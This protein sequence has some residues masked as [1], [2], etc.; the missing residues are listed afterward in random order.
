MK[1][2]QVLLVVGLLITVSGCS[3]FKKSTDPQT[4]IQNMLSKTIELNS[5]AFNATGKI[6]SKNAV[7]ATT[8]D[9]DLTLQGG[10]FLTETQLPDLDLSMG[11]KVKTT[12]PVDGEI[13]GSLDLALKVV[14]STIYL[15]LVDVMLPLDI[16][17]KI[18]S[19]IDLY[20]GKW[21][22]IPNTLLPDGI[23]NQ[24]E[25]TAESNAKKVKIKELVKKTQFFE[26]IESNEEGDNYVYK[27]KFNTDN[28]KVF[29]QEVGKINNQEVSAEELA[30]LQDLN[31]I[32][33]YSFTLYI[34]QKTHYLDKMILSL[35][36]KEEGNN[37]EI[38]FSSK[39]N[40]FN[41]LAK[42]TAPDGAEEFNPMSLMGLGMMMESS[43]GESL[44]EENNFSELETGS[45]ELLQIEESFPQD[46]LVGTGVE[47]E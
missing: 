39:N 21:F 3:L 33:N 45:G 14:A 35:I 17:S 10:V 19:M 38:T 40:N 22:S 27:T 42:I 25:V 20:K 15:Q 24:L 16:Q 47:V 2:I 26:V 1:K 4:V 37:L 41:S 7:D 28:L 12:D 23:K 43:Q 11:L 9:A 6:L 34:N 36:T 5:Y 46:V 44:L 8:V 31:Q 30:G 13:D 32:Y 29:I 18:G